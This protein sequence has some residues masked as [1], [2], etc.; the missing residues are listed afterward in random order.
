MQKVVKF[1]LFFA[2]VLTTFSINNQVFG[3][4][5]QKWT[6]SYNDAK[7]HFQNGEY[8]EAIIIYDQILEIQP[9]NIST[10]NM[11]G[12]TF[13]NMEDHQNSLKQFFQVLQN[14]PKNVIALIGMGVGF[15]NLGEYNEALIY[16]KKQIMKNQIM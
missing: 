12:I 6:S 1:L 3:Q 15:G 11:K 8:R 2:I 9:D 14:D 13:S 5:D 10:L 4:I 7:M 16:L